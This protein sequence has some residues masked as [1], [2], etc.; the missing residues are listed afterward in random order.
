[1]DTDLAAYALPPADRGVGLD[2]RLWFSDAEARTGSHAQ[3]LAVVR[4]AD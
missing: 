3:S 2:I 4:D 1:M